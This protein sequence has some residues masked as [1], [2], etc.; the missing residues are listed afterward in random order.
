VFGDRLS[1]ALLLLVWLG[2]ETLMVTWGGHGNVS[3]GAGLWVVVFHSAG[4]WQFV[5]F[6]GW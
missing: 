3:E 6:G 1:G 5:G 2:A 4:S